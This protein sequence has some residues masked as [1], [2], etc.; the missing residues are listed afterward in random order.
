[1]MARS[2]ACCGGE[3]SSCVMTESQ[4][5]MPPIAAAKIS[6]WSPIAKS[7]DVATPGPAFDGAPAGSAIPCQ[8]GSRRPA[9]TSATSGKPMFPS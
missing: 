5:G 2:Y 1:M 6:G 7:G 9:T 8:P 3:Q 4:T